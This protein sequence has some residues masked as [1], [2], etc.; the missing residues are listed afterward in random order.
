MAFYSPLCDYI[1]TPEDVQFNSPTAWFATVAHEFTH[2][3]G[4][5]SRTNRSNE[6]QKDGRAG[7]A[8]EEL[9][10]ELGAVFLSALSALA[11]FV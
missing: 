4:H 3:T 6:K 7:Y 2:W 5:K 11:A 1:S 9:V 8:F 10:A